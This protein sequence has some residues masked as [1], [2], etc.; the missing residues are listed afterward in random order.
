METGMYVVV[1]GLDSAHPMQGL[2]VDPR[3]ELDPT[4]TVKAWCGQIKRREREMQRDLT[5][6]AFLN[7]VVP[8]HPA[9]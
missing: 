1:S 4:H 8:L 6:F 3:S 5:F 9:L 7:P 2:T